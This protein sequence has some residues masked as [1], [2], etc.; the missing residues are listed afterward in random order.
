MHLLTVFSHPFT[1]KYPAA[2]M[3]ALN[4]PFRREGHSVDVL[5]LHAENFDP[6]FT[7]ADHA[8]F[9]GGPVPADVAVMHRRVEAADRLAFVF[10]VYWWGMPALMKGW[11]ERVFT[12]GWAYQFGKGVQDRGKEPPSALLGNVPTILIGIGGSSRRTYA[13]YGYDEAMRT[14][15]DVGTFVYCGITD[16]ESHLIH[17]VEGE[18]NRDN[19]AQGLKQIHEV[20]LEFRSPHRIVRNAKENHLRD[21]VA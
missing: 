15:L 7:E 1:D 9:W 21:R 10:P 19:R 18:H 11:L 16:V 3:D 14:Q 13:K 8:H 5:D 20:A 12:G 6:R 2:V 17:D 4:E